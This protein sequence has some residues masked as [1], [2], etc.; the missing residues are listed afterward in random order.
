MAQAIHRWSDLTGYRPA[1]KSPRQQA[2]ILERHAGM[3]F[4]PLLALNPFWR[5]P[6]TA[7]LKLRISVIVTGDFGNVTGLRTGVAASGIGQ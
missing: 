4:L 6:S 5:A 7:M 1:P 2:A 3:G